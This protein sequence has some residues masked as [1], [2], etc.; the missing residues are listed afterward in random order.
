MQLATA[1]H[2]KRIDDREAVAQAHA[3]RE[4]AR[5]RGA[6]IAG[7]SVYDFAPIAARDKI[8]AAEA[9]ARREAAFHASP[10]GAALAAVATMRTALRAALMQLEATDSARSRGDGSMAKNADEL[11]ALVRGLLPDAL[12]LSLAAHEQA[13][14]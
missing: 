2:L 14:A 11:V 3:S 1:K 4:A 5:H 7:V 13:A 9:S 6:S 8:A 12:G 10:D